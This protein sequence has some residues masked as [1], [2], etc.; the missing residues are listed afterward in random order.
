[1]RLRKQQ[2]RNEKVNEQQQGII[3]GRR[4]MKEI[5]CRGLGCPQPVLRA[6]QALE[7][8]KEG[9]FI[10]IVDN[11]SA[12]DN[13]ERFAK[14]Q[15]CNVKIME[16]GQDFYLHI[17]KGGEGKEATL[18]QKKE[19]IVV[20]INSQFMGIGENELGSILMKSFLKTLIELEPKPSA[21]IFINSGVRLTS[22][23]SDVL[24]TLTELSKKGVEILSCGT[25]LDFY[26]LKEKLKVGRVSNMFEIAQSLLTA[27]RLI[28]P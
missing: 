3:E 18:P 13:I 26:G 25:C 19:K 27:D 14:S 16:K 7:E 6:K 17:R 24:E 15:R 20:Y 11:Q 12:R 5:D 21:V 9:E 28:R 4:T 1:V 2:E 8:E 22:E 23:G 10:L